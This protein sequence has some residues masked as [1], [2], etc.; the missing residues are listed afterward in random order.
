MEEKIET[1]HNKPVKEKLGWCRLGT[2]SQEVSVGKTYSI[3]EG[4]N[5][6]LGGLNVYPDIIDAISYTNKGQKLYRIAVHNGIDSEDLGHISASRWTP[7]WS[8]DE[9]D[10]FRRFAKRHAIEYVHYIQPYC[11]K[12][13]YRAILGWLRRGETER[14]DKIMQ[15]TEKLYHKLIKDGN[16]GSAQAALAVQASAHID[17]FLAASETSVYV[18]QVMVWKILQRRG[19]GYRP[20]VA[21]KLFGMVRSRLGKELER[22]VLKENEN[23]QENG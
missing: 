3:E 15:V 9:T 22:M 13:H 10:V 20:E 1:I 14:L 4:D 2:I 17:P 7:L 12:K 19:M 5:I 11:K 23:V 21:G 8:V 6:F 16:I 18:G